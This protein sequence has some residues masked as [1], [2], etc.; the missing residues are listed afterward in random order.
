MNFSIKEWIFGGKTFCFCLPTRLGAIFLSFLTLLLA[1][2][3]SVV[4]WFEV[5]SS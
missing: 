3:L 1:G 5:T 4:L 2:I